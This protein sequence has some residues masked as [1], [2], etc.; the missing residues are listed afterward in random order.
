MC[1]HL[2]TG[3]TQIIQTSQKKWL[4]ATRL[5]SLLKIDAVRTDSNQC[6]SSSQAWRCKQL[7]KYRMMIICLQQRSDTDTLADTQTQC[8]WTDCR[9]PPLSTH[10]VVVSRSPEGCFCD[11]FRFLSVF[12]LENKLHLS[13]PCSKHCACW[14]VEQKV[15][16]LSS[17][18]FHP[19]H[20]LT[21]SLLRSF[22]YLKQILLI[23]II[24]WYL[25]II[26]QGQKMPITFSPTWSNRNTH[27]I[28]F[29]RH[30]INN[31]EE[32]QSE[33]SVRVKPACVEKF[34]KCHIYSCLKLILCLQ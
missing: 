4:Y 11:F 33:Q 32:N 21:L 20:L 30:R 14:Q 25:N 15:S 26:F 34:L 13:P 6:A 17:R 2:L 31:V 19:S 12:P 7:N 22:I 8:D 5:T 1:E 16:G 28:Y 23:P 29:I 24:S 18:S 10:A 3:K 27:H 9:G